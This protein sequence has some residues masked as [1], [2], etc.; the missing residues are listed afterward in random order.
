MKQEIANAPILANFDPN[1][2]ITIQTDASQYG[3]GFRLRL[4]AT[5]WKASFLCI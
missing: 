1:K 5:K 3:L 4:F 2:E